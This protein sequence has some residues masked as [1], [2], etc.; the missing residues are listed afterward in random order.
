MFKS[1]YTSKEIE[2]LNAG[3]TVYVCNAMLGGEFPFEVIRSTASTVT[4]DYMGRPR[5]F[6][7][8]GSDVVWN[9]SDYLLLAA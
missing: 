5:R 4:I 6:A 8:R 9:E 3:D 7:F 1:H 2:N